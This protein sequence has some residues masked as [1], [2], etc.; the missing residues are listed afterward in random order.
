MTRPLAV[1]L[2]FAMASAPA[3][4]LSF[5]R[6][7][8]RPYQARTVAPP[9]F[10]NGSRIGSIMRAGNIYLSLADAIALAIENNLDVELL[11]YAIPIAETETLRAKGGGLPRGVYYT[12]AQ[13]PAGVGGPQSPL[14]T[15]AATQSAPGT[16]VAAN[17]LELGVLAEP[18]NNL[19][20]Q[21]NIPLSNGSPIPAFDPSLFANYNWTHQTVLNA[22]TSTSGI[23]ALQNNIQTGNAG[24]QQG[25]SPGTNISV[26]FNNTEEFTNSP[27]NIVSPFISSDLALN[28]TQPLV[29]GFGR[30]LNRRFIRIG[31]AEEQITS[32]LFRQQL[33]E[34][35]YGVVRLYTDL[36]ALAEDVKVK[37]G[38]VAFAQK[39]LDDTT[40]QVQEGTIAPLE[41]SRARAQVSGS[42]QDLIN[43]RGLVEEQ[44]AILKN[45]ITRRGVEDAE[46]RNARIIATDSLSMPADEAGLALD[47]L[48]DQAYRNRPDL[49]QAEVQTKISEINLEGSRNNLRPELDL[50]GTAQNNGLAGQPVAVAVDPRF[51]GGFGTVLDQIATRKNPTYAIGLNLTLPL[52]NRVAQ[53]DALRDEL[54][55]RQTQIRERQLRNQVQLEVEDALIAMRRARASYEAAAETRALQEQS[56]GLEQTRYSEGVSTAFFVIQY[57]SYVAQARSAEVAAK[58]AYLKAR[59]AL[60]RAVGSILNTQGVSVEA[61]KKRG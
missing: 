37:E 20:T 31:A 17:A 38:T 55:V 27:R 18:L 29:R 13:A 41:L 46:V 49:G 19:S 3:A 8:L 56:L 40:L 52:R 43:A 26:A 23:G 50:V 1:Y 5:L 11:R 58:S 9:D 34:I 54:Q 45:V 24:Y 57:E 32:L 22:N 10:H 33:I 16:T 42:R 7:S 36:V 21:T 28:V 48:L 6:P 12:I 30:R 47:Q 25:F 35:V 44:E 61:A 14:I 59:A 60:E 2:S 4:D 15:Q 39:L 53:A 51:S